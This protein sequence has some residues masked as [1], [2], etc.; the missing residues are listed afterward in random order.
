MNSYSSKS[1]L[2]NLLY[3]SG[4][5]GMISVEVLSKTELQYFNQLK[6]LLTLEEERQ[7]IKAIPCIS[8]RWE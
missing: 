4:L 8:W 5:I 3:L 1:Q 2:G 6:D 7:I